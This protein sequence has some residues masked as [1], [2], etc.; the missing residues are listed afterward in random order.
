MKAL[1]LV[2]TKGLV[3]AI[4]GADAMLK[5]ANVG[6]VDKT[7]VGSGLVTITIDGDVGAVK[8]SVDAAVAAI[9]RVNADALVS[10]HVIPRPDIS[11]EGL[12]YPPK[13]TD[14]GPEPGPDSDPEPAPDNTPDAEPEADLE[15]EA[16]VEP[17]AE[18]EAVVE[19]VAPAVEPE[20]DAQADAPEP[21]IEAAPESEPEV[22]AEDTEPEP[23]PEPVPEP[24]ETPADPES[25]DREDFDRLVAGGAADAALEALNKLKLVKVKKLAREYKDFPMEAKKISRASKKKLLEAF[26][27]HF[28]K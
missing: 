4:E 3:A 16:E 5:A 11:I 2:E 14:P 9:E 25:M 26:E 22:P 17:V 1:G 21:E 24:V 13:D 28:K 19:A 12:I 23:A 15:P 8:A 7:K 20:A 27:A 10:T 18:V 6:L